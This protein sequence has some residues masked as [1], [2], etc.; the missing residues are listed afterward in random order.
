[1]TF[2]YDFWA[3]VITGLTVTFLFTISALLIRLI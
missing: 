3:S 2:G 1:M